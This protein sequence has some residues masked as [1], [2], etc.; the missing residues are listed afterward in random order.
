MF[1]N[2]YETEDMRMKFA[3]SNRHSYAT[4]NAHYIKRREERDMF[5]AQLNYNLNVV[6]GE[7]SFLGW[8]MNAKFVF[9]YYLTK[10][11]QNI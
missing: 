7:L 9:V 10:P 11:T 4:A 2:S 1:Q 5:E 3:A 8:K 6:S